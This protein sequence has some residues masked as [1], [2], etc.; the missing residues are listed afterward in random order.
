VEL[1]GVRIWSMVVLKVLAL[2]RLASK[3]LI[4]DDNNGEL[5]VICPR[6]GLDSLLFFFFEFTTVLCGFFVVDAVKVYSNNLSVLRFSRLFNKCE[7]FCK[8]PVLEAFELK[9]LLFDR[10]E[11]VGRWEGSDSSIQLSCKLSC[12][13]LTSSCNKSKLHD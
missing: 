7:A 8:G 5:A 6:V 13:S 1:E 9:G 10:V 2:D 4:E 3:L 12:H 11:A